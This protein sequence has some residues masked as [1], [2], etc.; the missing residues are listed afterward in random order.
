VLQTNVD[1]LRLE[2][3][4]LRRLAHPASHPR[5]GNFLSVL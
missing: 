1:L 3:D 5:T 2:Q 4:L